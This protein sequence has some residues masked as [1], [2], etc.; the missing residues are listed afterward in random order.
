MA[1]LLADVTTKPRYG[2]RTQAAFVRALRFLKTGSPTTPR[3]NVTSLLR[4][5]DLNPAIFVC[6]MSLLNDG[7]DKDPKKIRETDEFRALTDHL[8]LQPSERQHGGK[9]HDATDSH[10]AS[11]VLLE[12]FSYMILIFRAREIEEAAAVERRESYEQEL[13]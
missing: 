4:I 7:V 12:V 5:H 13:L 8:G 10:K 9:S 3:F 11:L 2:V 1:D 6:A